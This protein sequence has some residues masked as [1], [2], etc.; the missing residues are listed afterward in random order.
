MEQAGRY[1][2]SWDRA[3]SIDPKSIIFGRAMLGEEHDIKVVTDA[4]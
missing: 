3:V 4:A 2:S 1:H